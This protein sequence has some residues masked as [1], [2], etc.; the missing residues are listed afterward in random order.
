[1]KDSP[2]SREQIPLDS[3]ISFLEIQMVARGGY[4]DQIWNRFNW[5][6]TL[7]LGLVAFFFSRSQ[8]TLSEPV[9][10]VGVPAVGALVALLWLLM[11][12]EDYASIR[13]HNRTVRNTEQLIRQQF[14][15][16]GIEIPVL[17]EKHPFRFRQNW[18]LF[19]F[20]MLILI[21]WIV[22]YRVKLLI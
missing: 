11:G 18:L 22:V 9:L 4:S 10:S 15:D 1:M 16:I 8:T 6:L 7:Q 13:R 2:D 3:L 12:A 19:F 17:G 21:A 14:Q 5:I 20:P